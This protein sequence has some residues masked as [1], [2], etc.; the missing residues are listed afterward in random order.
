MAVQ[1]EHEKKHEEAKAKVQRRAHDSF[2]DL[3]ADALT[4]GERRT[5]AAFV[6]AGDV[7]E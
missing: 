6:H 4:D 1:T 2:F 3:P 7:R 5:Q